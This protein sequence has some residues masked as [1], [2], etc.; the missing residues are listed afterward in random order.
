MNKKITVIGAGNMGQSLIRG[1]LSSGF[2][3]N[4]IFFIDSDPTVVISL[5]NQGIE[6]KDLFDFRDIDIIVIAVKPQA[7]D[8]LLVD[9]SLNSLEDTVLISVVAGK[10][11]KT[12]QDV[13]G[14]LPIIRAMPNTPAT[15]GKGVTALCASDEVNEEQKVLSQKLLESVGSVIWFEEAMIDIVTAISG[16]GPAY[17]FYFIECLIGSAVQA[18]MK[19][20]LAR[21]LAIMTVYGSA[22]Y[23]L[24]SEQNLQELRKRV[25]SPGG[26]TEAA[27]E[28]LTNGDFK[29]C[30]NLAINQAKKRSEELN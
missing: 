18:G 16:S 26:T 24:E 8:S 3:K 4:N 7:L 2:K 22:N 10:K 5:N 23:A 13:L 25:T 30:I 12:Y 15:I 29:D 6:S 27:L 11:I 1:W 17:V 14:N 21:E 9:L 20:D 28:V 19:E